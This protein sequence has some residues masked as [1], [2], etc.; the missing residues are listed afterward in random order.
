MAKKLASRFLLLAA[1]WAALQGSLSWMNLVAGALFGGL[2]LWFVYAVVDR[3]ELGVYKSFFERP[4]AWQARRSWY[5]IVLV[6]VFIWE[7]IVS[8]LQVAYEVMRPRMR[9]RPGVVALPL[10]VRSDLEITLL[11]NLITL[12]PGTLSID[13]SSDKKTLYIH[14]MFIGDDE[15]NQVRREIKES[16]ERSVIRAVGFSEGP[17]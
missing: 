13:V 11:A 4:L 1:V 8:S 15:A 16:L 3:E 14:S 12:T 7:L 5:V 17:G 6:L 2:V 10:D 9:L